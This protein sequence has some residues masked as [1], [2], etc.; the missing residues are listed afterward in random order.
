MIIN[1]SNNSNNNTIG[2]FG[3]T[4]HWKNFAPTSIP[5]AFAVHLRTLDA[6]ALEHVP[7]SFHWS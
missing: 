4:L 5:Y 3:Q 6:P 1:N 7:A 2:D